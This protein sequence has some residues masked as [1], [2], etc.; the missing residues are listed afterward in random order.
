MMQNGAAARYKIAE[1]KAEAGPF[2]NC[3]AVLVQI[4]HWAFTSSALNTENITQI[5]Y[6]DLFLILAGFYAKIWLKILSIIVNFLA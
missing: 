5:I 4:E 2:P 6:I 3:E 1:F